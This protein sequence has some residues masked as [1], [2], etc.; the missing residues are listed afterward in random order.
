[1][2]EDTPLKI[3]MV[4]PTY[5]FRGGISH[6]TTL[7]Y[8]HLRRRHA[9][10]FF[11][12]SRQY[13]RW[14]FPGTTDR[15]TSGA[16]LREPGSRPVLDS[17]N[18]LSWFKLARM[19]AAGGYDVLVIPWWVAFW[20][21]QFWT[22]ALWTRR[23]SGTRVLFLCHN[24]VA[25]ETSPLSAALTRSVLRQGDCFLVH[26]GTDEQNL[27]AIRPQAPVRRCFHPTYD[28]FD[29]DMPQADDLRRQLGLSG[30]VLLFFGFVREYKGLKVLLQAL[31]EVAAKMDV[32]LLVVG[33]FWK[34][35]QDYLDE[36]ARLG[37]SERVVIID[38][39]IPNEEVNAYFS[40]ADLVV[41]PYL[42]ATGSGVVQ[43]AFGFGKPVVATRV[44]SLPE[45]IS[46]GQT[47]FL[48]PPADPGALAAAIL[49]FFAEGRCAAFSAQILAEKERF[50]WDHLVAAIEE[51]ARS[52][53]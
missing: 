9:V 11:A 20:A 39:Y 38:R 44:G 45:V 43:T 33:E 17:L 25:H 7:L 21:P 36:I 53:P 19:I 3:A 52:A 24:V 5:P 18:P 27:Q 2:T 29:A 23:F 22:I 26:S 46:D 32:T 30:R 12:F 16:A 34:D 4:G 13:P 10:D 31:P 47:G 6:Y 35:K 41:Q 1:M 42:S 15:D 28:V 51:L 49:R 8:R 48:V 40:A 14:L 37:L 50:S